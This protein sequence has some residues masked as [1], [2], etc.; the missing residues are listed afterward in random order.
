MRSFFSGPV[1]LVSCV[2]LCMGMPFLNLGELSFIFLL[3][4]CFNLCLGFFIQ[5]LQLIDFIFHGSQGSCIF[6][7]CICLHLPFLQL[8]QFL[9]FVF[10]SWYPVLYLIHSASMVFHCAPTGLLHFFFPFSFLLAFSSVLFFIISLLN[11]SSPELSSLFHSTVCVF[12][13]FNQGF[14]PG[15]QGVTGVLVVVYVIA[16]VRSD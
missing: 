6:F 3:K 13:D 14:I 4:T 15:Y 12:L 16:W 9:C 1:Y 11:S 10:Q 7:S 5:C 8:A 2:P